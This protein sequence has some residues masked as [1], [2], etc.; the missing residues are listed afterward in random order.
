MLRLHVPAKTDASVPAQP[1]EP[2]PMHM[3]TF[4]SYAACPAN[5]LDAIFWYRGSAIISAKHSS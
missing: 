2:S 1:S 4:P 5:I 3:R